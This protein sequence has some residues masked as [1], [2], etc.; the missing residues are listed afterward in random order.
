MVHCRDCAFWTVP[1]TGEEYGRQ[2]IGFGSC[3][4]P[5]FHIT[6]DLRENTPTTDVW[7]EDDEGWGFQTGGD[8]G[9][10]HGTSKQA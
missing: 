7:V 1:S 3:V 9:C 10:I 4:N 8:F 5:H 6:Y 2:M